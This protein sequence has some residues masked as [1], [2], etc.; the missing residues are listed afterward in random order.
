MQRA[1]NA[2]RRA[3]QARLDRVHT[4]GDAIGKASTGPIRG[5]IDVTYE[6]KSRGFQ[7][8]AGIPSPCDDREQAEFKALMAVR[9]EAW[10][11]L[12]GKHM[13]G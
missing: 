10:I 13:K 8:N 1:S 9:H 4:I 12:I 11:A 7:V 3:S 5:D 6:G 2:M